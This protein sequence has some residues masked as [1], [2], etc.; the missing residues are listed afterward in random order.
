MSDEP[1]AFELQA[2]GMEKSLDG[3]QLV[4]LQRRGLQQ[5]PHFR[6]GKRRSIQRGEYRFCSHPHERARV[7]MNEL[8]PGSLDPNDSVS[9]FTEV[10]PSPRITR[11]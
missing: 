3:R 8:R 2:E 4:A 6:V 5:L 10:F 7:G 1:H 9:A 11:S